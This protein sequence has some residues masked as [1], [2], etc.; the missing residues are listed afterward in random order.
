MF[1]PGQRIFGAIAGMVLL[2]FVVLWFSGMLT[3]L[4]SA[5]QEA[6]TAKG[7]AGAAIEAGAE[8]TNIIGNVMAAD[9]AVDSNVK[10]GRDAILAR[11]AGHSN[12]AAVRAACRLRSHFDSERCA[13]L[14]RAD[15]ERAARA[16]G[17][18]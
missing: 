2:V 1:T 11:P 4:L 14:R 6:R 15:T 12:D 10:G 13:A 18:R 9:A 5:K 16:G 7:Q 17:E 3:G 8:A